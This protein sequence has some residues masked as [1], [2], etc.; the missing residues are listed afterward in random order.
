MPHHHSKGADHGNKDRSVKQAE[1]ERRRK[2]KCTTL[3]G[4]A[5]SAE[6]KRQAKQQC[7]K[8][9]QSRRTEVQE[10]GQE[11]IGKRGDK[12]T[13]VMLTADDYGKVFYDC[14]NHSEDYDV[15]TIMSTLSNVLVEACF[16]AD[17]EPT[18]YSPG[19]VRIDMDKA[20]YPTVEVFRTVAGVINQVAQQNPDH[21]KIY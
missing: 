12:M 14:L 10:S 5:F 16:R 11:R 7:F 2:E 3:S 6:D 20:P 17:Y 1:E 15:C 21:I 8:D 18:E 13:K 9:S 19:H 4:A